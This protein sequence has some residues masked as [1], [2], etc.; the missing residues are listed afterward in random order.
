MV[1]KKAAL[2]ALT[3][4]TALAAAA[5][6]QTALAQAQYSGAS[7]HA[8][9]VEIP[10]NKSQ[11]V[12]ADVPIDRAMIGNEEIADILPVSDRSVYVLGKAIGTTSLTLYDRSNQVIA[13]MD[14]AVGPDVVSLREHMSDLLPGEG[15]DA[16]MSGGSIVLSGTVSDAGTADRAVQLAKAYAGAPDKVVNLMTL[17]GSQQVM[18]EVRFAEVSR[19]V[20]KELGVRTFFNSGRFSGVTGPGSAL[21]PGAGT[22]NFGNGDLEV[23]D[24][25]DAFGVVTRSFTDVLGLDVDIAIDALEEKGLAKTLAEPTL[26]AL[27]GQRASFLAGG[28]FP[29]PVVQGGGGAGGQNGI[30]VE[31]KSFGVGLGFTP[32]VLSNKVINLIVEPEVSSIDENASIQLNG[33]RIPGLQTRRASTVL[34][35]RDGES[36]A[37]AGLLQ[38]D[39][40]TTVE[41]IPILGSIPIIGTLFRSSGFQKGETELLI[42]VTPRLVAP[43]RPEQVRLPTDRIA[44]PVAVDVLLN[45][46][47]GRPVELEPIQG[48]TPANTAQA[49]ETAAQEATDGYEF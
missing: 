9:T 47:T 5:L 41:Q 12:T 27:S 30:T 4:T 34:E 23:A 2:A 48:P 37:I 36:F 40:Q 6:P 11:V 26:V 19:T 43:I 14:I 3:L 8:G 32:T 29:I 38:R 22:S 16:R 13:V 31:F 1:T 49:S 28:E 15:V 42:I 20:G 44:D 7:M 35:L 17:G 25:T 45:G 46:A 18:L 33:I 24:I 10:I 21:R 39:F